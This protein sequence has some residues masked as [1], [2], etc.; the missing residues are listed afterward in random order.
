MNTGFG[1]GMTTDAS[2]RRLRLPVQ[3]IGGVWEFKF[4]GQIPVSDGAQAELV[5]NRAS[6][7]DR[8]FLKATESRAP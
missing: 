1:I 2:Q 3:F 8:N 7:S 4:G 6:I 5:V